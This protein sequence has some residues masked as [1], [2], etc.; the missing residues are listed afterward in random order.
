MRADRKE[1][2]F[3]RRA[4]RQ[5]RPQQFDRQQ[6]RAERQQQRFDRRSAD[7]LFAPRVNDQQRTVDDVRTARF[8]GRGYRPNAPVRN[9]IGRGYLISG[10]VRSSS[11]CSAIAHAR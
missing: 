8:D 3:E 2:R 10:T 11:D 1:K 7:R 4:Q 6:Q 9:S 5:E